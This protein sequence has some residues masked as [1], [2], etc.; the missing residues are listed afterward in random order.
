M[1]PADDSAL[2]V[3]PHRPAPRPRGRLDPIAIAARRLLE[4][5]APV[6][7]Q[8]SVA[9]LWLKPML[10]NRCD[11]GTVGRLLRELQT[12]G[13]GL[14]TWGKRLREQMDRVLRGLR[15]FLD[16]RRRIDW[17]GYAAWI[18]AGEPVPVP[19]PPP[20]RPKRRKPRASAPPKP[21]PAPPKPPPAPPRP[22]ILPLRPRS[23][24]PR[25][26]RFPLAEKDR[27]PGLLHPRR[28]TAARIAARGITTLGQLFD[29]WS[30]RPDLVTATYDEVRLDLH[31]AFTKIEKATRNDGTVD[32]IK[33]AR[34]RNCVLYPRQ[35][36]PIDPAHY[37][38]KLTR[39]VRLL[40][41]TDFSETHQRVL[42][43]RL[44][45]GDLHHRAAPSIA[46]RLRLGEVT[47]YEHERD[48]HR[49][50]ARIVEHDDYS[51]LTVHLRPELL[52][53]LRQLALDPLGQPRDRPLPAEWEKIA[54]E[55]WGPA[56][57]ESRF[58]MSL[59]P[60]MLDWTGPQDIGTT[61]RVLP[62][63]R[64]RVHLQLRA[65][66]GGLTAEELEEC[67]GPD[68]EDIGKAELIEY[69]DKTRMIYLFDGRY[70]AGSFT[71]VLGDAC[72]ALLQE[73]GQPLHLA[74]MA[75]A[76]H[77]RLPR[78]KIANLQMAVGKALRLDPARR[79]ERVRGISLYGL[80][81]WQLKSRPLAGIVEAIFRQQRRPLDHGEL[82]HEIRLLRP[83]E[84]KDLIELLVDN[85]DYRRLGLALWEWNARA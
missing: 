2:P 71:D 49:A 67:L 1:L 33:Y 40:V 76:L 72:A 39:A 21:P 41:R 55:R 45:R 30:S 38:T 10:Q 7:Q 84:E 70:R 65:T 47:F 60:R 73:A 25:L 28:N 37:L 64:T 68:R 36:G 17:D 57:A 54:T 79:F 59:V 58:A 56:A 61:A 8:R 24:P 14:E 18:A 77:P 50:L 83:V 15:I 42:E 32:W 16:R 48:V 53:P 6:E 27:H 23:A 9:C 80:A 69:L 43:A 85:P 20:L 19:A 66:P 62:D 22:A 3:S 13:N 44:L 34:K 26:P 74:Q 5:L 82:L 78:Y 63:W 51:G 4:E 35:A 52:E 75:E 11:N 31:G 81:D 46:R 12:G 29:V